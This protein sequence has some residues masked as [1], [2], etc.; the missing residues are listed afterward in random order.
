LDENSIV[1]LNVDISKLA[2]IAALMPFLKAVALTIKTE[3]A[4]K[5][6][7]DA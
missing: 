3:A 2:Y 4:P 7:T 6:N 5:W 1:S